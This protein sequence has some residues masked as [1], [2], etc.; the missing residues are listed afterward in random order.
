MTAKD[1]IDEVKL[2]LQRSQV[3]ISLGDAFI[4]SAVNRARR[5][6]QK[7]TLQL[8]PERYGRIDVAPISNAEIYPLYQQI[9][10]YA[11]QNLQVVRH[12][13]PIDFI[14]AEVVILQ[15]SSDESPIY[16]SEARP[17]SK[18]EMFTAMMSSW[19]VPTPTT[20]MYCVERDMSVATM[21]YVIY[22]AGIE[23]SATLLYDKYAQVQL[24]VW[25]RAALNDL[26]DMLVQDIDSV[27]PAYLQELVI[28]QAE[29]YCLNTLEITHVAASTL[30][31]IQRLEGQIKD[32][33]A[34]DSDL[35]PQLL[36]SKEGI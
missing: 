17:A 10:S 11:N 26:T 4:L 19:A 5:K 13:L 30:K 7:D 22:L 9:N 31:E 6:V 35:R 24:E 15:Y 2:R 28:L 27:I 8:Y 3:S 21:P 14:E 16:R 29:F 1:Y 36:P 32:S 34:V 18:W 20:P 12:V 33:Y 23:E 25:Y